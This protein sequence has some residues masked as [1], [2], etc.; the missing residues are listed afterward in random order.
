M[1]GLRLRPDITVGSTISPWD[2]FWAV[3]WWCIEAKIWPWYAVQVAWDCMKNNRDEP[4]S[5]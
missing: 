1:W 2:H 4:Y 3:F 5:P